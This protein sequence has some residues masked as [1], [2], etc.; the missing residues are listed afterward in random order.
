MNP[1]RRLMKFVAGA[2]VATAIG[3]CA[4]SLAASTIPPTAKAILPTR[5]QVFKGDFDSMTPRRQIRV[6]VP[7]SRT[8][9]FNDR[10]AQRSLTADAVQ[11]FE[12]WLN[13]NLK[14]GALPIT[15]SVMPT[16]RDRLIPLLNQGKADIVA[17]NLT[18]TPEHG[19]TSSSMSGQPYL[20]KCAN[21]TPSQLGNG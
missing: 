3:C 15:V 10:G 5:G 11:E 7:Y 20:V 6:A 17:G 1:Y 2:T 9:F 8:L 19:A 16:T 12:R 18:I 21:D 4:N 14:T 13:T